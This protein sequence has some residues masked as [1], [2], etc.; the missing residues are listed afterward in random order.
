MARTDR[1]VAARG[2]E[3]LYVHSLFEFG[4]AYLDALGPALEF[5]R[6]FVTPEYQ[7][8][9]ALAMLWRGIGEWLNR[10]PEIRALTGV[11]SFDRRYDDETLSLMVIALQTH[12]AM[13]PS[14]RLAARPRTP[15]ELTM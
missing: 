13:P 5:G 15:F 1:V 8:T 9:H 12:H 3:G 4:D 2:C 10:E 11:A 7:G 6:S 14:V